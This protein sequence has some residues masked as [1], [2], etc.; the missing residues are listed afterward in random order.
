MKSPHDIASP[1]GAER[2]SCILTAAKWCFLNFGFAKTSFEDI[3]KRASISRTLLYHHFRNKEELF[4]AVFADWLL[5]RHPAAQKAAAAP[6]DPYQRLIEVCRV[7]VLEPWADMV[8]TPMG[9]EF[10]AACERL[11]PEI[12][13]RH[14]EVAIECVTAL[15]GNR[16]AAEIFLLSL[17]GLLS[18][19]PAVDLLDRRIHILAAYFVQPT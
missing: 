8:G 11:D 4:T 12:G 17:D 9:G 3:A 10:F 19:Q 16:E 2:R 13:A 6:G 1:K 5:S 14:R 18:D 15:I 7:L